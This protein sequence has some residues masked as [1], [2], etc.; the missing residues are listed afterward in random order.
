M[1]KATH[2]PVDRA[3]APAS[4]LPLETWRALAIVAFV[5]LVAF[6]FLLL[7]GANAIDPWTPRL[8]IAALCLA[9]FVLTYTS[10]KVRANPG[11]LAYPILLVLLVYA[12]ALAFA[13]GLATPYVLALML[14][15]FASS[16]AIQPL[17]RFLFYQAFGLGVAAFAAA[18]APTPPGTRPILLVS[19]ASAS[20]FSY[21][22]RRSLAESERR[23]ARSEAK[24]RS[25]VESSAD[26]IVVL[27]PEGRI[28]YAGPS[29]EHVLGYTPRELEG[30]HALE[31]I[32]PD[33][34]PVSTAVLEAAF[35]G[36][37]DATPAVEVRA[38]HRDGS[39]RTFQGRA[40][41]IRREDGR[42]GILLN[43]TDITARKEA[44]AER[45]RLIR[46]LR[47]ANATVKKLRGL[48]SVCAECKRFRNEK[49][50]WEH[51]DAYL[52]R[53]SYVD[54]SHGLCPDCA[55]RLYGS[56]LDDVDPGGSG[57]PSNG[58]SGP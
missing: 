26:V 17:G 25:L 2:D 35:A 7:A 12:I 34:A 24:F 18:L 30:R 1:G 52:A 11:K 47:E 27:D 53:A 23:L 49:G 5:L 38:R 48:L 4:D 10:D 20:V 8:A 44:E 9:F 56:L 50:A 36:N 29:V 33:D 51:L 55:H 22:V 32:H 57:A 43:A 45:E 46:S 37:G 58:P 3:H 42:A 31:L 13:N 19:M 14:T 40:K 21:L 41:R 16:I 6:G 15:F 28:A 39:W 54:V